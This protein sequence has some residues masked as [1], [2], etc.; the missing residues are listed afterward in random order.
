MNVTYL[1]ALKQLGR[2]RKQLTSPRRLILVASAAAIAVAASSTLT[3]AAWTDNEWTHTNVGT[4]VVGDCTTNTLFQ[5]RAWGRQLTG[6]VAGFNLDTLAGV[7]GVTVTNN[8]TLGA[9]VPASVH[10]VTPPGNKTTYVSKLPIGVLGAED[11]LIG[12]VLGL[13]LNLPIGSAGTY[14]QWGQAKGNGLAHGAAGLV[15]DQSGAVDITGLGSGASTAPDAA[16]INLEKLLPAALAGLSLKVGAVASSATMDSCEMVSGWPQMT[17]NPSPTRKYGI[18]SMDLNANV[19]AVETIR[20]SGNDLVKAVPG[21]LDSL[22]GTGGLST[23]ITNGVVDLLGAVTGGLGLGTVTT[24]TEVHT[25]PVLSAVTDMLSETMTDGALTIDLGAGTVRIDI[26]RLV[27]GPNGLN[28]LEPNHELILDAATVNALTVQLGAMLD[29]WKNRLLVAVQKALWSVT[30]TSTTH[31]PLTAATIDLKVGPTSIGQLIGKPDGIGAPSAPTV[32]VK[33]LG[34]G[35]P[36]VVTLLVK[37]VTDLLKVSGNG[38]VAEALISTVLNEGGLASTLVSNLG[39]DLAALTAPVAKAAGVILTPFS[40]LVSVRVNV[41]T[42][43][44]WGGSP[45]RPLQASELANVPTT[46]TEYKVSAIRVS[47]INDAN[48][49]AVSLANSSAGPAKVR[50]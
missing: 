24:I 26:A 48:A 13:G 33:V 7:D 47:L 25:E 29:S 19:P 8:G 50:P 36:G 30:I 27:D 45:L 22:A 28:K 14:T 2:I 18:A 10:E 42:E 15:S 21:S 34:L 38:E 1:G 23:A 44:P 40:K 35:L 31:I 16:S 11:P 9:A 43:Q 20:K 6:T 46:G 12:A 39:K 5:N 4:A 49:L 3:Q 37:P 17:Q 32:D 41:Q